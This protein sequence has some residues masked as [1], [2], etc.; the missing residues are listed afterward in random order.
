MQKFFCTEISQFIASSL[1]YFL[2]HGI[3][4]RSITCDVTQLLM[5]PPLMLLVGPQQVN[6]VKQS[7]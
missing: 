6:G 2:C 4:G 7:G 3:V 5:A 1:D